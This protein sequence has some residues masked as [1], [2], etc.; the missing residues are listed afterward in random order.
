MNYVII[1]ICASFIKFSLLMSSQ[2]SQF[3][4]SSFPL[5]TITD[6]DIFEQIATLQKENVQNRK[7]KLEKL[8]ED[9]AKL[10]K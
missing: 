5:V 2:F 4:E 8:K 3:Y 7:Q 9:V 6:T 10:F 1:K